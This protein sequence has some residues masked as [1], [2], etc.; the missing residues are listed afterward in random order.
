MHFDLK[1]FLRTGR[2]PYTAAL[3]CDLSGWDWPGYEPVGPVTGEFGAALD[4]NGKAQL[5]LALQAEVTAP[6]A[7]CLAPASCSCSIQRH[8]SVGQADLESDELELPISEQGVLDID[9]LAFQELVLEF[10]T[11]L[12]CS[13]D[14][15]GLCPVC[16][17]PKAAGCSCCTAEA[18]TPAANQGLAIL[19]QLLSEDSH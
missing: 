3:E 8:W 13:P 18:E 5:H 7:R 14:C 11:V 9:E 4:E 19:K 15:Q 16:G 17:Q 12:L 2:V 10:P 1:Q 6:C